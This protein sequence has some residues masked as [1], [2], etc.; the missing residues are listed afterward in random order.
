MSIQDTHGFIKPYCK[1]CT[2]DFRNRI[3]SIALRALI[4]HHAH[5]MACFD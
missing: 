5:I 1:F 2:G 4:S 3:S